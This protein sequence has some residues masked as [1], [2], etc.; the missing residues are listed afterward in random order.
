MTP[1]AIPPYQRRGA[2]S[3]QPPPPLPGAAQ[4]QVVQ[5]VKPGGVDPIQP[6]AQVSRQCVGLPRRC[7]QA[8]QHAHPPVP[9][10]RR[11]I[12][13]IEH[14]L[15]RLRVIVGVG[16]GYPG[17]DHRANQRQQNLRRQLRRIQCQRHLPQQGSQRRII[18]A[19]Q[20]D[21]NALAAAQFRRRRRPM[22]ATIGYDHPPESAFAPQRRGHRPAHR[23][24]A[25]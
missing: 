20:S 12:L 5:L 15:Q 6:L 22:P 2:E 14:R 17:L 25:Q 18:G 4:S 9:R 11:Q 3:R 13:R 8:G 21:G 19:V 10:Q 16:V 23:A 24:A 7:A 1:A